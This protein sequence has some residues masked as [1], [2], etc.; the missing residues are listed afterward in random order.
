MNWN[1]TCAAAGIALLA[2]AM[3]VIAAGTTDAQPVVPES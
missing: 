1:K 2:L 3:P